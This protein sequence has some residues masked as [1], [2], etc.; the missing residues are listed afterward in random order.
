MEQ[1][2]FNT[3][4]EKYINGT[5]SPA[6]EKQL[7]EW[8]RSANHRVVEVPVDNEDEPE[9]LRTRMLSNL[10]AYI[11]GTDIPGTAIKTK[12]KNSW[13]QAAAAVFIILSGVA[14]YLLWQ[15]APEN[16]TA[17]TTGKQIINDLPAGGDKAVLTL[18]DGSVIVL[19]SAANGTVAQQGNTQ[20]IKSDSGQLV[21]TI[22]SYEAISVPQFNTILTPRGGQYKIILPDGS[23]AWLN[24]ASSLRFPTAF[25]GRERLVELTGEGY[26]EVKKDASKTFIVRLNESTTVKVLGTKFNINA[27]SDEPFINTTLLQGKVN[28]SSGNHQAVLKPGQ[29]AEITAGKTQITIAENA[30]TEA[31]IAWKEGLFKLTMADLQTVMRQVA[32]WYDVEIVYKDGLPAV[33]IVGTVSRNMSLSNVLKLLEVSGV[34]CSLNGR[35]LTVSGK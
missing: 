32:R 35:V 14:G 9:Q 33:H 22:N 10:Q 15:P 5:A 7:L 3:L 8:Y 1:A 28:I 2:E 34:H 21:Y 4:I 6:E 30:D 16:K 31:A 11:A 26:F 17:T 27:Y 19:D 24:A 29:A 13:L 18:A 12:R 23:V 25:T 20:I